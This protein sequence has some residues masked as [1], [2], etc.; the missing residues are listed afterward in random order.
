MDMP[1]GQTI[2][3][4]EAIDYAKERYQE[5][6]SKT[7]KALKVPFIQAGTDLS[8]LKELET[9]WMAELNQGLAQEK[10]ELDT[11]KDELDTSKDEFTFKIPQADGNGGSSDEDCEDLETVTS[12]KYI[13]YTASIKKEGSA[14]MSK[15]PLL[16]DEIDVDIDGFGNDLGLEKK[17]NSDDDLTDDEEDESSTT[18]DK[19]FCVIKKLAR[20]QGIWTMEL[21]DGIM[22]VKGI[23]YFF[24]KAFLEA[25]W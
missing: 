24:K 12:S 6:I 18:E 16:A 20:D 2:E 13:M 17:V 4:K 3:E 5:V 14:A 15:P 7:I 11:S 25:K 8:V 1:S 19:I 21:H 10:L 9:L 23:D 22:R